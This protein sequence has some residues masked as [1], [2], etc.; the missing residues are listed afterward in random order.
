MTLPLDA[1]IGDAPQSDA[2]AASPDTLSGL[3]PAA[4]ASLAALMAPQPLTSSS[5]G[6]FASRME[7]I[8]ASCSAAASFAALHASA[9]ERRESQSDRSSSSRALRLRDSSFMSAGVRM[10]ASR[11]RTGAGAVTT[12][13]WTEFAA[14]VDSPTAVSRAT[15]RNL[16]ASTQC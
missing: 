15:M 14:R 13:A 9:S 8:A 16:S 7:R 11:S 2:N 12:S 6:A 1:S 10:P 3:S 5:A 4:M